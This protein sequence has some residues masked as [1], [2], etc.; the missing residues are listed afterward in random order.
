MP[1][2]DLAM[3][4]CWGADDAAVR[5]G[6]GRFKEPGKDGPYIVPLY[7]G[8]KIGPLTDIGREPLAI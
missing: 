8:G 5:P 7:S 4:K 2:S 1:L 6:P 3:L